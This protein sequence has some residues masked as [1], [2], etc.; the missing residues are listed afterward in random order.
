M[1]ANICR[2]SWAV[3]DMSRD[4]KQWALALPTLRTNN[5]TVRSFFYDT[6]RYRGGKMVA[7]GINSVSMAFFAIAEKVN[8]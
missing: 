6:F 2:V 7:S 1:Y 4:T 5:S 3:K 8:K